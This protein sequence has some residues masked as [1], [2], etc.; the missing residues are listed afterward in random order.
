MQQCLYTE[1]G[2]SWYH[3]F[4]PLD[5][6]KKFLSRF[7]QFLRPTRNNNIKIQ[8]KSEI[9][10]YRELT[11]ISTAFQR[12][13]IFELIGIVFYFF[14]EINRQKAQI[15]R[16]LVEIECIPKIQISIDIL[17]AER[18]ATGGTDGVESEFAI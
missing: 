7:A 1:E 12:T 17:T 10:L 14:W 18:G 8:S 2:V 11:S 16:D 13:A 5:S 6:S 3:L 4:Q 9:R 15:S